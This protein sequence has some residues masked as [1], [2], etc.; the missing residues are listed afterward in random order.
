MNIVPEIRTRTA[1]ANLNLN[2]NLV[3][4]QNSPPSNIR[5]SIKFLNQSEQSYPTET[6][7]TNADSSLILN[8]KEKISRKAI[9]E[10]LTCA[11]EHF[12]DEMKSKIASQI[13]IL[14][15]SNTPHL[16]TSE[17]QNLLK[18]IYQLRNSISKGQQSE[19]VKAIR[20]LEKMIYSCLLAEDLK[21][22]NEYYKQKISDLSNPGTI[23]N[24][25]IKADI[26]I[27]GGCS[28]SDRLTAIKAYGQLGFSHTHTLDA[29]DEGIVGTVNEEKFQAAAGVETKFDCTNE[30]AVSANCEISAQKTLMTGVNYASAPD[31]FRE[32]YSHRRF[33]YKR[34]HKLDTLF[35]KKHSLIYHQRLAQN[36]QPLFEK[37][38]EALTGKKIESQSPIP[39]QAD[40]KP[41]RINTAGFTTKAQVNAQF[42]SLANAGAKLQYDF[43][44]TH[45]EVDVHENMFDAILN[46]ENKESKENIEQRKKNLDQ[47]ADHYHKAFSS[48]FTNK[49]VWNGTRLRDDVSLADISQAVTSLSNTIDAYSRSVQK[50]SAGLHS[51]GKVKHAF[52]QSWGVQR[53]GR[54]GFLQCAEVMLATLVSRLPVGDAL[55]EPTN[56]LLTTMTTLNNKI[57][58]PVFTYDAKK[59][60]QL[61]GFKKVLTINNHAHMVTAELNANI[62]NPTIHGGG[63]V[64]IACIKKNVDNPYRIRC[65]EYR[66]VEV[67]L[68]GNV[69]LTN[70][71]SK[72]TSQ[73]ASEAGVELSALHSSVA[74]AFNTTADVSKGV[75]IIVR[76]FAPNWS[77]N[78]D[79]KR[80][81][82]HQVTYVQLLSKTNISEN[83]S[84]PLTGVDLGINI[85][86]SINKTEVVVQNMGTDTLNYLILRYNYLVD[87]DEEKSVWQ[88]FIKENSNNLTKLMANVLIP[89][90]NSNN[91]LNLL[92]KE[93]MDKTPSAEQEQLWEHYAQVRKDILSVK[94]DATHFDKGVEGLLTLLSWHKETTDDLFKSSLAPIDMPKPGKRILW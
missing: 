3:Y 47:L 17:A 56:E 9:C 18:E 28:L 15:K 82:S 40:V 71:L 79:G 83:I 30:I 66:D 31:Y 67:T 16:A 61:V 58:A 43:S 12:A 63:K 6:A 25:N 2:K 87:R 64:S 48:L 68:T 37:S 27:G 45:I 36:N 23:I 75:K 33:T 14:H 8:D 38:W 50:Y 34:L 42:A 1:Q 77:R 89:G 78:F 7:A 80:K 72:L 85:G 59:L 93:K 53:S 65:G 90:T 4:P 70:V 11:K 39:F 21:N 92:F 41:K 49:D 88:R 5:T 19:L 76:Y 20:Y 51:E 29:D 10:L 26:K 62:G 60:K 54:Y 94:Y 84:I 73:F 81:Y 35:T 52:E 69:T 22:S 24:R 32:K 74:D 86:A 55:N 57:I 13:E 46:K 44:K 91:E